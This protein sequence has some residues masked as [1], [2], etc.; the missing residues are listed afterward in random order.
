[1][2][3]ERSVTSMPSYQSPMSKERSV[4]SMPSYRSPMSQERSVVSMRSV[5]PEDSELVSRFEN[6]Q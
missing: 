5:N 1:M 4:T 6:F 2:S 3:K